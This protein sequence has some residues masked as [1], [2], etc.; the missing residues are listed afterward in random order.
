[1]AHLTPEE[2]ASQAATPAWKALPVIQDRQAALRPAVAGHRFDAAGMTA[3]LQA[4]NSL[5]AVDPVPD[6]L[7]AMAQGLI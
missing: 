4:F 3:A 6:V 7:Q 2:Q 5:Q 1:M